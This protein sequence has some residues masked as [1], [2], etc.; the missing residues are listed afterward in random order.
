[1]EGPNL[2]L[3]VVGSVDSTGNRSVF[4][5][6]VPHATLHAVCEPIECL[7]RDSKDPVE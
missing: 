7:P 6:G 5:K 1:M 2:P 4:S 3:I